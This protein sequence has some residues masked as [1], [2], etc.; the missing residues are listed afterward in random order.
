MFV[1]LQNKEITEK[2]SKERERER[3]RERESPT[4]LM[5]KYGGIK[6]YE[7]VRAI[8]LYEKLKF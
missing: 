4:E 6:S 8:C 5:M 2:R 7:V 1:F 3:V